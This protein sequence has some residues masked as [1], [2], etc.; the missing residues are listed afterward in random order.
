P[1]GACEWLRH[2]A[3]S[4]GIP[5]LYAARHT[6]HLRPWVSYLPTGRMSRSSVDAYHGAADVAA[7]EVGRKRLG[8]LIEADSAGDDPPEVTRLQVGGNAL[9]HRQA[10]L[11]PRRRRVDAE[12]GHPAQ[13]ERHHRGLELRA[14]GQPD[15]GNVAPEVHGA[16]EPGERLAPEVVDRAAEAGGLE[17]AGAPVDGLPVE[18]FSR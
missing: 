7:L 11:A 13:D 15:A 18:H 2:R 5:I 17:R 12:Q 8:Q 4:K 1:T 6:G 9:P 10:P 3:T 16:R 14:R